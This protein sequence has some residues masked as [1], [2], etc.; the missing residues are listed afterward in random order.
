MARTDE[1]IN[2]ATQELR[3]SRRR[4]LH[5]VTAL[6]VILPFYAQTVSCQTSSE[7][8]TQKSCR[9]FVQ[10]FYDWYL[11]KEAA[12]GNPSMPSVDAVLK[13]NRNILSPELYQRLNTDLDAEARCRGEICGL[14]FDPFLNSQ[15]PSAQ[16]KAAS[17][18]HKGSSYWVDVYGI[19][20]GQRREH[21]VP[22][23]VQQDGRWIF[24][25]FH[26]GKNKWTDDSNLLRILKD[27]Q[28]DR[29]KK[30]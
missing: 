12:S 1:R 4:A 5:I 21:I 26:Y 22:E 18:K 13:R 10:A 2:F 16:F 14:D 27:L 11:S 9:E 28:V 25:N 8:E 20:S 15:D 23:L 24:V 7:Q 30:P 17:V 3:F 19:E 6:V 29:K